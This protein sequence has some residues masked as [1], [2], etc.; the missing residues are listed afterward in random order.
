MT[1]SHNKPLSTD[2][3]AAA[4]DVLT[5]DVAVIG[6][7]PA[8]LMAAHRLAMAGVRVQL[9]DAM[10][11][12]GRKFLLAGRGGLNLTHSEPQEP[13][14]G[15]FGAQQQV[16][17]TWLQ[18]FGADEVQ[19]WA[20]GLGVET[21][22]GTSGRIFPKDMKAAPLLRAWLSALR[23][24]GVQLFMRHR[25]LGWDDAGALR[26]AT[27]DGEKTVRPRAT[28]L[29]LGGA[30]WARLGSDG[31]W[32]PVLAQAGIAVT[33]LVAAN[34]GFEV[35]QAS[36][37][38]KLLA[39]GAPASA[40]APA[41]GDVVEDGSRRN[42]LRSMLGLDGAAPVGWSP[43][44]AE[45]FAGQPFKSVAIKF[46]SANGTPFAR[47][48]EFVATDKGVEG[49]LVYA[50]SSLLRDTIAAQGHA[51]FYIDL[52]P[53]HTPERVLVE[54]RHPRGTRSL[55]SHLKSR[56][57]LDG[58]KMA[59]LYEVLGKDGMLDAALLA[60]TIKA[61]PITVV[62]PSPIDEAISTAGGVA[63]EALTPELMSTAQPGVFCAGE[64][65]DWEAPTGGYLLTAALS[66]GVRAAQGVEQ[67][68]KK[69][70]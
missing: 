65:L 47:R 51:T 58:I 37:A 30:S 19:A 10:P 29:A 9:F 69:A 24:S 67:Y 22:V 2:S 5:P 43:F 50:V 48:G 49:S 3:H 64:M 23:T 57:G 8:G 14:V 1:D 16:V 42:F 56:L 39:E 54:V 35:M 15:R 11:S 20:H 12:V 4:G 52:L 17:G 25:W 26:F 21:F 44:F 70:V 60:R 34:C 32:A 38:Q 36:N 27:P 33:P 45:K 63:L 18:D 31:K 62:A 28:V 59:L 61:A 66:S 53:N 6:G 13:F 46:D 41:A 55:A 68:L 7:G 40:P